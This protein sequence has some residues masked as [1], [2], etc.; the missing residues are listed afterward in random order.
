MALEAL[1]TIQESIIRNINGPMRREA[2]V[3]NIGTTSDGSAVR[4]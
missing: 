1:N 4:K 2:P 3:C